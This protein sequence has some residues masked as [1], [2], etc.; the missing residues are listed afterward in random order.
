MPREPM[1]GGQNGSHVLPL[2]YSVNRRA[3]EFCT[4][5]ACVREDR[6]TPKRITVMQLRCEE[7]MGCCFKL[8]LCKEFAFA[9]GG[10]K[11]D[12]LYRYYTNL[13]IQFKTT[14]QPKTQ[15]ISFN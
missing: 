12:F 13:M 15:T 10:K 5:W 6:L 3:A 11:L 9:Y 2:T 1:K 4:S 7:G 8:L 14:A